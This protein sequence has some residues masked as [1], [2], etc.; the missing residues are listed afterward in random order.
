MIKL[1]ADR[2]K[3]DDDTVEIDCECGS[4][5]TLMANEIDVCPMCDRRYYIRK[6]ITIWELEEGEEIEDVEN[7]DELEETVMG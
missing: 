6:Q 1:E 2:I 4:E 3:T 5:V 7:W